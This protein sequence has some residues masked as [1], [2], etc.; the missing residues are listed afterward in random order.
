MVDL[1]LQPTQADLSRAVN[2][3]AHTGAATLMGE[4][5][6]IVATTERLG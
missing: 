1:R 4:T 2:D 5:S 6:V 3:R